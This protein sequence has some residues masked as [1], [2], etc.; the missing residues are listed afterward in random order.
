MYLSGPPG[1]AVVEHSHVAAVHCGLASCLNA[2]AYRLE[3]HQAADRPWKGPVER[4]QRNED[5][6][7]LEKWH[8]TNTYWP[9]DRR[10][11][12]ARTALVGH[13]EKCKRDPQLVARIH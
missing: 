3:E 8:D 1:Q 12:A 6:I 9:L 13:R 4:E 5:R 11:A 7:D 2:P 10:A